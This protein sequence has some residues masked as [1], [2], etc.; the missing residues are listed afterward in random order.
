VPLVTK[1]SAFACL[2]ERLARARTSPYLPVVGPTG[3]TKGERPDTDTG[4]EMALRISGKLIRFYVLYAAFVDDARC[5][6]PCLD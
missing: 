5:D 2:A 1:A 6:M 3:A 4:E